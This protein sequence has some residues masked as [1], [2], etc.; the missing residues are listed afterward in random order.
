M[1]VRE[2]RFEGEPR[3]PLLKL[4]FEEGKR[5]AFAQCGKLSRLVT[6][7]RNGGD[8]SFQYECLKTPVHAAIARNTVLNVTVP[9]ARV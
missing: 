1:E 2:C 3:R 6:P 7:A 9:W 8:N 5:F 4:D